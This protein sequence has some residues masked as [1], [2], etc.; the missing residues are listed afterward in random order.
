MKKVKTEKDVAKSLSK[1]TEVGNKGNKLPKILI[2]R[3]NEKIATF[4][5][6]KSDIC[7][8]LKVHAEQKSAIQ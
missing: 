1:L 3:E 2:D 5:R 8:D 6:F 7:A 4:K